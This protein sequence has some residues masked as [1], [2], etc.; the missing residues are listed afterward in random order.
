MCE[1]FALSCSDRDRATKGLPVFQQRGSWCH[2]GWGVGWYDGP[3]GRVKKSG[4]DV[5]VSD[6]FFE[7][8]DEAR[9]NVIV[10][11][12]RYSTG[13]SADTCN[14]HPFKIH[15]CGRDWLFAHNGSVP[16]VVAQDYPSRVE[17]YS[18]IDS[19]RIFTFLID[20]LER[21]LRGGTT[22]G[23]YPAMVRASRRL[24]ERFEG[25]VNYLLTDGASLFVLNHYTSRPI[26]FTRRDKPYGSAFV[27]TTVDGLTNERWRKLPPNRILVVNNGELLVL[28]DPVA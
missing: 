12:V 24:I 18:E 1:L 27:A 13:G 19:A 11:H 17:P 28:S 2:D 10:A 5:N 23:M 3:T 15:A 4:E 25:N 22:R 8:V 16:P 21:Y 9:S 26:Y 14:S 7:A 6:R 20:E